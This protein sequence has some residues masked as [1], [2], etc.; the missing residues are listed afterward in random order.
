MQV[1]LTIGGYG[2]VAMLY[3]CLDELLPIFAAAPSDQGERE[4]ANEVLHPFFS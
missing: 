1:L 4:L 2:M 3:C